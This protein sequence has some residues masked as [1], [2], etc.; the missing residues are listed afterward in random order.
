MVNVDTGRD[1]LTWDDY[2]EKIA[3]G[4]MAPFPAHP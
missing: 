1:S 2:Q 3:R 4:E